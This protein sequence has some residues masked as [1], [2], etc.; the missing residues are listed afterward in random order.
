MSEFLKHVHVFDDGDF[1][2]CQIQYFE[3][4]QAVQ[5]LNYPNAVEWQIY[6][7]QVVMVIMASIVH[8][9]FKM[10]VS[11]FWWQT[12]KSNQHLPYLGKS[13]YSNRSGLPS[14]QW[15]CCSNPAWSVMGTPTGAQSLGYLPKHM[16]ISS[17]PIKNKQANLTKWWE[18]KNKTK[19]FL[20]SVFQG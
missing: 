11:G 2:V 6:W 8:R 19:H 20:T 10:C 5:A 13:D 1:V 14:S 12:V 16:R 4:L 9:Y 3:L 15:G 17:Q 18:I 7:T